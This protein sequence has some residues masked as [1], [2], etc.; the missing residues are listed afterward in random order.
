M[1]SATMTEE[2]EW[3]LPKDVPMRARLDAVE[4]RTINY[5][6]NGE[7][8]SF[9]KWKW[10]FSILEDEYAGL[11][12][13]GETEDRLTSHPDNK[14]RQWGETLR[15][16]AFEFGEGIDTDDLLAT[17][18]VIVVDNTSRPKSE[19]GTYYDCPVTDVYPLSAYAD[20]TGQPGF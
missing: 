7:K 5:E 11:R 15:D 6:K 9:D 2:S 18:C 16:K 12:A 14:V 20:L 13:W 1:P 10:E 19:G 3:K 8:R 4:V 17:E